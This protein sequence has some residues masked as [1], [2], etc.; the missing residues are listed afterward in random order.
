[1]PTIDIDGIE[2]FYD[3]QGMGDTLVLLPG[4]GFDHRYYRFAV[5]LFAPHYRVISFDP[6][7]IGASEKVDDNYTVEIWASD[8]VKAI[9]KISEKPVHLLGTS[10]G[11]S[12]AMAV[13]ETAPEL[14]RSLII[15]GSFSELDR[16]AEINFSLRSKLIA[17]LGLSEE[18][19]T[20]MGLW[21]MSR[22]FINSDEGYE[23]MKQNLALITRNDPVLYKKFVDSVLAWGR[24]LPGQEN[25]PKFTA[26]LSNIKTPTLVIG[27]G[28]DHLIPLSLSEKIA[29]HIPGAE[30]FVMQ[31]GGHIPFIEKP[32]DACAAVLEFLKQN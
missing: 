23:Q 31:E 25:E 22:S 30:L 13:A 4:L 21:T 3:E 32:H 2:I 12:M 20:Y 29:S 27:S 10:L 8:F 17:R 14:L 5:P 9:A 15:V 26:K 1:M 7:G 11:G 19:A 18:V 28:N 24:C 16:A 6:R